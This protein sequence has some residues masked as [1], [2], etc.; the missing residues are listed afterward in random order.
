MD[1]NK[2]IVLV[3]KVVALAMGIVSIVL[4][5]SPAKRIWI[6]TSHCWGLGWQP[7]LLPL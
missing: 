7:W 4:G 3:F 2:I 5:F 6:P 1:T